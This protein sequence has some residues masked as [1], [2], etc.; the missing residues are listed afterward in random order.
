MSQNRLFKKVTDFKTITLNV[1]IL[2]GS[3]KSQI[4]G[5]EE[6]ILKI[7]VNS[8]P[9]EGGANKECIEI[10]SKEFKAAKSFIKIVSGGKSRNKVVK[11]E[12]AS[13]ERI[14]EHFKKYNLSN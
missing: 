5:Y 13:L 6:G 11:I 8:P 1:R 7:K 4:I 2:P 9:V 3:S 14:N 12:N 10:L